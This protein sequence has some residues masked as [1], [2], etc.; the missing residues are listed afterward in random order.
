VAAGIGAFLEAVPA[1]ALALR[2][3]GS[4]YLLHVA[5]QGLGGVARSSTARKLAFRDDP[6]RCLTCGGPLAT[7]GEALAAGPDRALALEAPHLGM[8]PNRRHVPN[9]AERSAR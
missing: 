3:A 8:S 1:A 7:L 5:F 4:A 2:V 6:A 9:R